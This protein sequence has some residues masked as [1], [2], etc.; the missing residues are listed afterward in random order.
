MVRSLDIS[1]LVYPNTTK[2]LPTRTVGLGDTPVSFTITIT[3]NDYYYYYYS[4]VEV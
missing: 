4:V 2:Q 1:H 3:T